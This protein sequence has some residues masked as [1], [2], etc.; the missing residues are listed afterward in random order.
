DDPADTTNVKNQVTNEYN[1]YGQLK[2]QRQD[3]DSV[4]DGSG[5]ATRDVLYGF[6]ASKGQRLQKITY[7][8][9]RIV[10]SVYNG[11]SGIDDAISRANI[12][13]E[14]NAGA[15]GTSIAQYTYLGGGTV[16]K[17]DYATPGV[18][19]TRINGSGAYDGLDLL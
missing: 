18:T 8:N 19:L 5:T 17:L 2:K 12:L 15:A 16:L 13:A 3:I 6:D 7:P 11:H 9:G 1:G 10:W 4:V 14:D